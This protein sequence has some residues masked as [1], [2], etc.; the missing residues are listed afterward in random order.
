MKVTMVAII[1]R[2]WRLITPVS[3]GENLYKMLEKN[4]SY[5]HN[6]GDDWLVNFITVL[7]KKEKKMWFDG[8]EHEWWLSSEIHDKLW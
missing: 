7:A 8:D 6:T 2:L 5:W 1:S 3:K 4:E